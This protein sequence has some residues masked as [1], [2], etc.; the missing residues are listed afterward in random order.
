MRAPLIAFAVIASQM[1]AGGAVALCRT[2]ESIISTYD[3]R[4]IEADFYPLYGAAALEAIR[5]FNIQLEESGS[6]DRAEGDAVLVADPESAE[7]GFAYLFKD[8][9][10]IGTMWLR[11]DLIAVLTG[12]DI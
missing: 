1:V 9:C 12:G 2:P 4:Q 3:H 8:N 7:V 10:H 11:R 5:Q 6:Q